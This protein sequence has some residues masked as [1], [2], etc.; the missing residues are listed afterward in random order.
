MRKLIAG[1]ALIGALL[2]PMQ[3]EAQTSLTPDVWFTF[4]WSDLGPVGE[5]YLATTSTI[6]VVDCCVVGDMFEI[7]ADGSSLGTTSVVDPD[8]G[9]STGASTADA[10]WADA[11]LSKGMFTVTPGALI[12]LD[13]I[14]RTTSS[15]SGGGF[16]KAVTTPEPGTVALMLA[17]L[18]GMAFVGF[19]RRE[20]LQA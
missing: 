18:L 9:T 2:M 8:D 4:L 6:L 1:V 11:R 17:G 20:S 19:R 10:A 3:S 16:I 14:Q 12:S 5:T 15:N 13:V 7:F